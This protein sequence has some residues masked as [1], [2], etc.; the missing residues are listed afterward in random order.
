[1]KDMYMKDGGKSGGAHGKGGTKAAAKRNPNK[2]AKLNGAPTGPS[3]HMLGCTG[4]GGMD[5]DT[6]VDHRGRTYHFK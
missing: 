2:S 3:A 1:M 6:S 4:D 5:G